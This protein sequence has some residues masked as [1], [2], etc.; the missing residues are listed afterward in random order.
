MTPS[1]KRS[2]QQAPA[3]LR[4]AGPADVGAIVRVHQAAFP[5]FLMTQLGSRFLKHYYSCARRGDDA[6]CL[7]AVD[8]G[9]VVGFAVGA[10]DPP[11]YYAR[12]RKQRPALLL[13]A[14]GHL[15]VRP[16]VWRRTARS[17]AS[18]SNRSVG[19]CEHGLAELASLGV[20]P[21]R[22]GRG[23]G[24]T[25]VEEFVR[26]AAERGAGGVSLTTDAEGND[27]V[28]NFYLRH[29][30]TRIGEGLNGTR[31]LNEYV[32]VGVSGDDPS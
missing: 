18:M 20:V 4:E 5:D 22:G 2:E 17:A 12:L 1:G 7:V 26:L 21:E 11:A 9:D 19:E 24:G 29:G 25:L 16:A 30:F 28:N 23:L 32:R 6:L 10:I 27:A 31:R 3:V 13:A 14:T 8:E 15:A